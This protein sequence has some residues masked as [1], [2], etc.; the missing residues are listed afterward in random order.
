MKKMDRPITF[1]GKTNLPPLD[2]FFFRSKSSVIR[3]AA[4]AACVAALSS[5][6]DFETLK[7]SA[8]WP[9]HQE[10]GVP[11]DA[12][13]WME[14]SADVRKSSIEKSFTLRTDDGAAGGQF[15]WLSERKFAFIPF[16]ELKTGR[17]YVME[18]PRSAEDKAGNTMK[19]DFISDFYAG[20]DTKKPRVLSSFPEKVDGGST[21]TS[22]DLDVVEV[23]FSKPMDPMTCES[24]FSIT[25]DVPGYFAWRD[26]GA[27]MDYV[28]TSRLAYATQYRVAVAATA[29]DR[30]GNAL[31]RE[32]TMVFITGD[33]FTR[34]FVCGTWESGTVPPPYWN[35]DAV[36]TGVRRSSAISIEFSE[37]M[38]RRR[39]ESAITLTPSAQ[40]LC[41]WSAGDT[42]LTFKPNEPL[43]SDAVYTLR[44]GTSAADINGHTLKKPYSVLFR[45]S[46]GDS[47]HLRVTAIMGSC[48][49]GGGPCPYEELY[50]GLALDWP[51]MID[52][53]PVDGQICST[54]YRFLFSFGN[55]AGPAA[56]DLY[57][58]L[59][60]IIIEGG[61]RPHLVDGFPGADPSTA[62]LVFDGLA[63]SES[64]TPELYRLTIA[65]GKGGVR[66]I[67]GN[68]MKADF[69]IEFKDRM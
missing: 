58:L 50:D 64:I 25:P 36:N 57:S 47:L 55:D 20:E 5:C 34:P 24:A 32:F 39:A 42:V 28:L 45:T 30:A 11:R 51:V 62:I 8:W 26:D 38:D 12:E 29:E 63:N 54:D 53:G 68:T 3:N 10:Y 69:V 21:R 41:A 35:T 46:A 7:V 44:V 59:D 33:D 18:L 6:S 15:K 48:G 19:E 16:D 49:E 60:S 27:R 56:V 2:A 17:R 37:A 22:I 13:I 9:S 67:Y 52:M 31:E 61:E 23:L 14:F 65:G 40:G 66:D 43:K 4:F 1:R